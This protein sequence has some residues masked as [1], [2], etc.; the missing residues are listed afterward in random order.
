M[1]SDEIQQK[2]KGISDSC[3]R[4]GYGQAL[5]DLIVD[6][7][8]DELAGIEISRERVLAAVNAAAKRTKTLTAPE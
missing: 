1:T 2:I 6:L 4:L 7:Q 5:I 8:A 3:Y